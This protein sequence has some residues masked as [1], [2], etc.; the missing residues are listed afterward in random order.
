MRFQLFRII[1]SVAKQST[2]STIDSQAT[3]I[4]NWCINTMSL[5]LLNLT[6][7]CRWTSTA[8]LPDYAGSTL[9]GAFGWA[10]KRCSCMLKSQ[11]CPDCILRGNCPYAFLF[12]TERYENTG[13]SVNA[14]PHPLVIQ[15][16]EDCEGDGREGA[17]F[18][19]SFLLIGRA[20]DF[21]P[22]I[23]HSINLMGKAGIGAWTKRGGGRFAL[24]TVTDGERAVFDAATGLLDQPTAREISVEAPTNGATTEAR[25]KRIG[26][27]LI[28]PLRL[29]QEN[30]LRADLPFS[31]L[32][33]A[34]LRRVAALENA[35]GPGEPALDY[36]GLI[37]GAK[38]VRLVESSLRWRELQR[39]SKRQE[40]HV[41]L[42]GL[43]GEAVY[44]G[45]L[46][47]FMPLLRYASQVNIGKQSLFGLGKITF[48]EL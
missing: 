21:T 19:F 26:I 2:V 36:A 48:E 22:H 34:V 9:R 35:Y 29:K 39:Y 37:Q 28:T 7:H 10:L 20:S 31:T 14:R 27:R 40:Q 6:C 46:T 45:D 12:A 3:L 11:E 32:I 5:S 18:S 30:K 33:R 24:E 1:A 42:S 41:S 17:A 38:S 4:F 8:R 47:E 23:V 15:P 43:M 25:T 13:N 44:E 16:G